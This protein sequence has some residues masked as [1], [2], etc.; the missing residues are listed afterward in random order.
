MYLGVDIGATKTLVAVLD[1]RG[2]IKE[3]TKFPTPQEY[4]NFLLELR[5]TLA[6]LATK[7]F[8]AGAIAVPGWL[9]RQHGRVIRLGSLRWA[10][11]P[12]QW[13]NK[14]IQAD[15]EKICHCPLATE[16]DANLAGLSEAMLL[17]EYDKVA[18]VTISTGIGTGFVD[19]QQ[20]D[21][22]LLDSEGGKVLL[23]HKDKLVP[24]E[25]FASGKAFYKHFG[26]KVADIPPSDI[27]AWQYIARHLA[28]GLY[29]N[30]AITQPDVIVIGGSVGTYFEH[31]AKPLREELK[32]YELPVV[33]I[34]KLTKAQRPE[35]AVVYGCYDMAK[36]RFGHGK[37]NS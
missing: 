30:I 17:P 35:E 22:G 1:E 4:D 23:P 37:N 24:W 31:F 36:Q 11:K 7:D 29:T 28:P 25:N 16:N 12:S 32:H 8:K 14:P 33:E 21:P 19:H 13:V 6:H 5:H 2:I 18:Y 26:K 15:C 10:N 9:D 34:P 3:K 27:V 20:L